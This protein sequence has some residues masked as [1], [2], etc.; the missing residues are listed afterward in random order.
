MNALTFSFI[1]KYVVSLYVSLFLQKLIAY[2]HLSG[3]AAD[4]TSP[5]KRLSDRIVDV[6]CGCFIGPQTEDGVQ[7][8][9]IKVFVC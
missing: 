2:G 6:I 3:S 5:G 8:Q 9:I 4:N 7:L 1:I